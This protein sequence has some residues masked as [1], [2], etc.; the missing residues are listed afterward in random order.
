ML[1]E[2]VHFDLDF[3]DPLTLGKKAL[4]ANL[5]DI[6]AMGGE[7]EYALIGIGMDS[8]TPLKT[9]SDVV[10]GIASRARVFGVRIVGGDTVASPQLVITITLLG[11]ATKGKAARRSGARV[12]DSV[13]VTGSLGDSAAGLR[14]LSSRDPSLKRSFPP[15]I[16][17][18]LDP[19]PRLAE[20]QIA[21][22]MGA[23]SMIDVSDGLLADLNHICK[24]SS[25]GA[26]LIADRIPISDQARKAAELLD[27]DPLD[28]ALSGGED[29]ELVITAPPGKDNQ[30]IDAIQ[31]VT[32]TE[33]SRIG[34]VTTGSGVIVTGKHRE[35]RI[36][37]YEHF[38]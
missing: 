13:L 9:A 19:N 4:S 7:A 32:S 30:I 2:G 6:A 15:L 22:S 21:T 12:G 27:L 26:E 25:V 23:N 31:S 16:D 37:G 3:T 5:S 17:K 10:Q 1:I 35:G 34:S 33:V 28:L 29:Y 11:K 24:M 20:G 14:V 38:K 8:S 36:F 18:H